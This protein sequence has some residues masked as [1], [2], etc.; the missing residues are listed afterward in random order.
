MKT[1]KRFPS[2]VISP[3]GHIYRVKDKNGKPCKTRLV[4]PR[5]DRDGYLKINLSEK[6]VS[7]TCKVHRLVAETFIPNP[8]RRSTVNHKDGN[9]TNNRVDNLEWLTRR[10]NL[11]ARV[12]SGRKT[13]TKAHRRV[14]AKYTLLKQ[15]LLL[16]HPSVSNLEMNE[17]S[18]IQWNEFIRQFPEEG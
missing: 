17:I 9:K 2:Y 8:K 13:I 6:G 4:K 12:G 16:V 15:L 11:K 1:L 7:T 14:I 10:Q 5:R 18:I 3:Q